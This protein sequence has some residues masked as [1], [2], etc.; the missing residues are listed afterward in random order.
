M[1]DLAYKG[2]VVLI[3]ASSTGIGFGMASL[4]S[5]LG[6]TVIIS[7]RSQKNIDSAL[8]K[9]KEQNQS[10]T[11]VGFP[12]HVARQKDR[13]R[14][15]Q[16]IKE[17]LGKVDVVCLNAAVSTH[18]GDFSEMKE[19]AMDKMYEVNIKAQIMMSQELVNREL[20]SKD[21]NFLVISSLTG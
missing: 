11:A 14:L 12:C 21:A 8:A 20:L 18:F 13:E 17:K 7:S 4:Y 2:K 9:L 3:T 10:S 19:I 16:F 15:Y 1:Q 6:A 5:Q